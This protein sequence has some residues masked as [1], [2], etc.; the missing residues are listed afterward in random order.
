MEKFGRF[1]E[2][3]NAFLTRITIFSQKVIFGLT[4]VKKLTMIVTL[5]HITVY[6]IFFQH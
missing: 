6:C 2:K 3:R 1:D 5:E 4:Y